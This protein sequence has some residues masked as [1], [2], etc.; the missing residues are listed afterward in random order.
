MGINRIKI[1]AASDNRKRRFRTDKGGLP[2]A[3]RLITH[4]RKQS[5]DYFLSASSIATATATV[6]PTMGE[7]C[8]ALR[9]GIKSG[10]PVADRLIT[11]GRKRGY[12]Y[13]LSAS[14]TATATA[15][16]APTMGLLPIPRKPIISTSNPPDGGFVPAAQ[17]L[18]EKESRLF[19]KQE[20]HRMKAVCCAFPLGLIL[21]HRLFTKQDL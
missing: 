16:V 18:L 4:G 2:V 7:Q 10:L 12:D 15:T 8:G 9:M 6:A 19:A 14:S 5:Y 20:T 11:H 1:I 13:F 3:D 17:G 21:S